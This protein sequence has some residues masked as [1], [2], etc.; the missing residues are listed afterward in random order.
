MCIYLN[1]ITIIKCFALL[2]QG[3]AIFIDADSGTASIIDDNEEVDDGE[4][5]ATIYQ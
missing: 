1:K 4:K 3:K 5:D 2:N